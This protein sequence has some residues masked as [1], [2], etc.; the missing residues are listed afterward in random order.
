MIAI[1]CQFAILAGPFSVTSHGI[2]C[3]AL[4]ALLLHPA[5]GF[6]FNILYGSHGELGVL[7]AHAL[8]SV[9][10]E[11]L[12]LGATFYPVSDSLQLLC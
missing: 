4:S 1:L 6:W 2:L 9:R 7:Q 3:G 12:R 5:S 8:V 11:S 10:A